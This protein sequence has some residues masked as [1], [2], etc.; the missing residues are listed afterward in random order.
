MTNK[1][2]CSKTKLKRKYDE[3]DLALGFTVN[4]GGHEERPVCS[5]GLKTLSHA[6]VLFG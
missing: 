2:Q 6:C 3:A 5:L 1:T 4:G